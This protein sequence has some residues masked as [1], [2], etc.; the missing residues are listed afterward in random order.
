MTGRI[1]TVVTVVAGVA[2]VAAPAG[3][4][5][6]AKKVKVEDNFYGPKKITVDLGTTVN[7]VQGEDATDVHDVKLTSGPKGVKKFHSDPMSS[8]TSYKRKLTKAGTYKILCTFH[9]EDDMR[10]TVVVRKKK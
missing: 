9:E 10:M 1:A 2:L 7:W 4:G 5:A 6:A 8:G 3:V